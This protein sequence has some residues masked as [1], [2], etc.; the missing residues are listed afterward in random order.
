MR[1]EFEIDGNLNVLVA[2]LQGAPD[3]VRDQARKVVAKGALNIK[4]D[5]QR[6]WSGYA[7]APA[8]PRA[9]TYDM[10]P[11][12]HIGAE[13]GPDKNRRQGA[14]GSLFE[15]GSPRNNPPIPG[16]LPALEAE[17]PRFE[18][19]MEDAAAAALERGR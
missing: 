3:A 9:I 17:R 7:H 4:K 13:I 18:Q 2:D 10:F 19:A 16:G 14:L 5:W 1:V 11:G 8:L 15:Y 12:T 6:R